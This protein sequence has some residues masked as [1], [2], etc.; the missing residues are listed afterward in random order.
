MHRL[1]SFPVSARAHVPPCV[2]RRKRY[3]VDDTSRPVCHADDAKQIRCHRVPRAMRANGPPPSR[4][5]RCLAVRRSPRAARRHVRR[6]AARECVRLHPSGL[7]LMVISGL[8]DRANVPIITRSAHGGLRR[9]S[10]APSS[11]LLHA[12]LPSLTSMAQ[13]SLPLCDRAATVPR[14][15]SATQRRDSDKGPSRD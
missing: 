15:R 7:T 14:S 4:P 2:A 10:R 1:A 12:H 6:T 11:A 3:I 8:D 9:H 13:C 5:Y